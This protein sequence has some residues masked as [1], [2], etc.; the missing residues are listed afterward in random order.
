M[1]S[2]EP[3]AQPGDGAQ[4]KG[5]A[6]ESPKDV[7]DGYFES[8][9]RR[10]VAARE[11]KQV[12]VAPTEK[13]SD[14]D[15]FI[16]D[17]WVGWMRPVL[18]LILLAGGYLAYNQKWIG[19]SA[20][21]VVIS[22]GLVLMVVYTV[23]M[24]VFDLL[25]DSRHKAGFAVIVALWGF[26]SGYP[27]LWR[28]GER[29]SQ[30][31]ARLTEANKPVKVT[32]DKTRGGQGPF[33]MAVRGNIKPTG[34]ETLVN[35]E[36]GVKAGAVEEKVEGKLEASVHQTQGRRGS[37][38]QWSEV[39]NQVEFALPDNLV[40]GEL[41]V[42]VDSVDNNLVDGLIVRFYPRPV[43]PNVYW[44]LGILVVLMMM[45]VESRVGDAQ[46]KTHLTMAAAS[47]LVFAA[48]FYHQA[49]PGRLVSPAI[50]AAFV[51]VIV[52][53][54]GGTALGWIVRKV[55]GRDAVRKKGERLKK[56]GDAEPEDKG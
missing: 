18:G 55:S 29:A 44:A 24:P 52:G 15:K 14:Y 6:P 22:L 38:S 47:T 50:E 37:R 36:V 2:K 19:D 41:E 32:V 9:H 13:K 43:S 4:P 23:A 17:H 8:R 20:T 21:G 25:E 34:Q 7:D 56:D 26:S 40:G 45:L 54:I 33:L 27:V 53:G 10:A 30:G 1:A 42:S 48:R 35:F 16:E 31:E 12:A 39:H 51:A 11:A 49:V 5:A 28:A 3:K 46:V